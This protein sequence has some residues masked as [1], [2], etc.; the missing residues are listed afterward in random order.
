MYAL[1]KNDRFNE[2]DL[3]MYLFLFFCIAAHLFT[4]NLI[5]EFKERLLPSLIKKVSLESI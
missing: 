3:R 4:K 2:Q 1:L 5:K